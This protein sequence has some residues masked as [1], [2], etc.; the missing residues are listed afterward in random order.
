MSVRDTAAEIAKCR[1]T[2]DDLDGHA[3]HMSRFFPLGNRRY[4]R[5][6]AKFGGDVRKLRLLLG[7]ALAA[8][9]LPLV[10]ESVEYL[11]RHVGMAITLL[12]V[13]V[14]WPHS[15]RATVEV[16]RLDAAH[17]R[18]RASRLELAAAPATD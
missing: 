17:L 9:I 11:P 18:E 2:A 7:I 3:D 8:A 10:A 6:R 5:L 12:L 15:V 4:E 16:C 1:K 13:W 14:L